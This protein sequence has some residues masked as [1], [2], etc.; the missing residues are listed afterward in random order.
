MAFVP[1]K[2]VRRLCDAYAAADTEGIAAWQLA[3][4]NALWSQAVRRIP[5]YIDIKDAAGLPVEFGSLDAFVRTVPPLEKADLQVA[6]AQCSFQTKPPDRYRAT[7]GSTGAPV[8]IPAWNVE[9][10]ETRADP[11]IGR[12]WYG[13]HPRDRLFLFWGHSHLLGSGWRG[14]LNGLL[15]FAKDTVLGYVP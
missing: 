9:F 6:G 1:E 2:D 11:W 5:H 7:G 3:R 15:R 4:I 8:Q 14:Q 10:R 13:V 12:H